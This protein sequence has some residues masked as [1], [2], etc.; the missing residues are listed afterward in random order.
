MQLNNE[1]DKLNQLIKLLNT[2]VK[3]K[4]EKLIAWNMSS[5]HNISE[6]CMIDSKFGN[7][8]VKN[9][10]L[11]DVESNMKSLFKID[12]ARSSDDYMGPDGLVDWIYVNKAMPSITNETLCL[13]LH[14]NKHLKPYVFL[15][16][17][18]VV[19]GFYQFSKEVVNKV[20]FQRDEILIW[21]RAFASYL[22]QKDFTYLE[23]QLLKRLF[24]ELCP[25]NC[26]PEVL[27]EAKKKDEKSLTHPYVIK[28]LLHLK[29]KGV[30]D[31]TISGDK[32]HYILFLDWLKG[33][34][35]TFKNYQTNTIPLFHVTNAHLLDFRLYLLNQVKSKRYNDHSASD[36]YYNIRAFFNF[37]T[38]ECLIPKDISSTLPP[39][40]FTKYRYREI[41]NEEDINH[42][43]K[44][45]SRYSS[46]PIRDKTAFSLMLL[47]GLRVGEVIKLRWEN[48]NFSSNTITIKGEKNKH[49]MLPL[50]MELRQ[51]LLDLR[52]SSSPLSHFV[53]SK[54]H[55][56]MRQLLYENYKLFSMIA[57]WNYRGGLHLFR[58]TYITRLSMKKD[59]PLQL[60]MKLA[61]HA[62]PFSTSLYIHRNEDMLTTA[63]NQ[64]VYI[65]E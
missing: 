55:S 48:I 39:I 59:I 37:L 2:D 61:R 23:K 54:K 36:I 34:I 58:H 52:S 1:F 35:N 53:F 33:T 46:N 8:D 64:I 14:N 12:Y 22:S 60:L 21:E 27:S 42:F 62:D 38:T 63:I 19:E 47:L 51:L 3:W 44:A 45:I 49:D 16:L 57:D 30:T 9:V 20:N 26:L 32:S 43:F 41:P 17:Y 65:E 24:N 28:Y 4:N 11:K 10:K 13:F 7:N 18:K 40:K 25:N 15:Q 31:R 6:E 5:T 50:S 56:A 29:N